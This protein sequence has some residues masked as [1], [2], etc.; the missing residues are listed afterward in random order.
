MLATALRQLDCQ[1]SRVTRR[2]AA[3][4]VAA[5]TAW[6]LLFAVAMTALAFWSCG[7]IC[8]DE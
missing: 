1:S 7:M 8:L 2:S 6:A 3:L 4:M 5:G